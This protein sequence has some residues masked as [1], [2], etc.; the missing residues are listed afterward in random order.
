MQSTLHCFG[1]GLVLFS[2]APSTLSFSRGASHASCQEMIPGHIR[3]QPRDP[4]HNHITL[5]TSASSYLPGQLI[6]VNVR[7]S[8]DFMG[9]LLQ[10]RSAEGARGRA[11]VRGRSRT[12]AGVRSTRV[13][14]VLVGGSWT[15]APP[16]THTLRCLSEGDTLTHS[17][18][19]LK[20][21]LSFVWRA[22]DT[23]MGDIR[24]YITVVQS[25]FV[26]WAGIESAVVCD[27]SRS[28]WCGSNITAVDGGNSI[29]SLQEDEVTALPALRA[30]RASDKQTNETA[31]PATTPGPPTP[32]S[33]ETKSYKSQETLTEVTRPVLEMNSSATLASLGVDHLTNQAVKE[34]NSPVILGSLQNA[35]KGSQTD[36]Y[37]SSGSFSG[38][39]EEAGTDSGVPVTHTEDPK[40]SFF[41]SNHLPFTAS[42]S[43]TESRGMEATT[44]LLPN[45]TVQNSTSPL[46]L[47]HSLASLPPL[48][49]GEMV[50]K[51]YF[52]DPKRP[53]IPETKDTTLNPKT[54]TTAI[55]STNHSFQN[56]Y[57][58]RPTSQ[59]PRGPNQN[60]TSSGKF[61][62]QSSSSQPWRTSLIKSQMS[63]IKDEMG[64]QSLPQ[65]PHLKPLLHSQTS[66]PKPFLQVQIPPSKPLLQSQTGTSQTFPFSQA[67]SSKPFSK[68]QT[69]SQNLILPS[70]SPTLQSYLQSHTTSSFT[71]AHP[72]SLQPLPNKLLNVPFHY[73]PVKNVPKSQPENG[74]S[75]P[76]TGPRQTS[77][78]HP[79][80]QTTAPLS[81]LLQ[82]LSSFP[83]AP[84]QTISTQTES[85][86]D[87]PPKALSISPQPSSQ[88]HFQTGAPQAHTFGWKQ[89]QSSVTPRSINPLPFTSRFEPTFTLSDSKEVKDLSKIKTMSPIFSSILSGTP[90][91]SFSVSNRL[92]NLHS[93][94][95]S[96]THT[97]P[98]SSL[99]HPSSTTP[100]YPSR[101]ST[102][103]SIQTSFTHALFSSSSSS[104]SMKNQPK[105]TPA[106][107]ALPSP[108]PISIPPHFPSVQLS[109]TSPRPSSLTPSNIPSS[110][111]SHYPSL[112]PFFSSVPLSTSSSSP[113]TSSQSITSSIF[114][115]PSSSTIS[116]ALSSSIA[117]SASSISS[118]SSPPSH[119]PYSSSVSTS[120]STSSSFLLGSS[121]S[122]NS[123]AT[124][125]SL[126]SSQSTSPHPEPSPA[127][128]HSLF[129]PL[130]ST[131]SHVPFQ[132]LTL[133]QRL[134]IQIA[135]SDP[136]PNLNPPTPR[137]VVHPNPEP[138]PNLDPDF[139]LNLGHELKPNLP[140]METKPKTKHAS[141][142]SGIP[143]REGKYPDIIPR[144]SAWELVMLLGCSAGLGMMMVVG[145]RYMYRQACGKQ[146]EV[147][148][149]DREREY[150]RGERGMIHV[151]E[152]GD[153]VRVRRIRE[154]S[155][156]LLAEYDILATPGD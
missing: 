106:L 144:H 77:S 110:N 85:Q 156:V 125:S 40:N 6:T 57:P 112:A 76:K 53:T 32:T 37:A 130:T 150:E 68:S 51:I 8:R 42:F 33:S 116:P 9:F 88:P 48:K 148:L 136:E 26:Y 151:Q 1:V 62:T 102:L 31:S 127:P 71:Q 5:R 108:S 3:T 134:L 113:F 2:L 14:P 63:L 84:P 109:S 139:K 66:S 92:S 34:R 74:P 17:D 29:F 72:L 131:S 50:R 111:S 94:F 86:S 7:S 107:T 47:L 69:S 143:D 41:S 75:G 58:P 64:S 149:N 135:S 155:F 97:L 39:T 153:L 65:N 98:A 19:Q 124:S 38:V 132:Q 18:K 49:D 101:G 90:S 28:P 56:T 36:T 20:K 122:S 118:A 141:N 89:T 52:Q 93:S 78:P 24:F 79:Q 137:T 99:V 27:G 59:N 146:T 30:H 44:T 82:P 43:S 60:Q 95:F 12:G 10:A 105:T 25:Y 80:L 103:V 61:E 140:N 104:Y 152:C 22:P 67:S 121:S 46:F 83:Q 123:S 96:F 15:L 81:S 55:P 115:S 4:Q 73:Q 70:K 11:G 114:S 128:R 87:T 91:P 119:P 117:S 35:T 120:T 54:T 138:H 21:N 145:V 100:L 16:G 147:T 45:I 13:G 154:N 133:G 126:V 129:N 23:P 142:P